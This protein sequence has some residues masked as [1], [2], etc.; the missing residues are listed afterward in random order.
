MLKPFEFA[1]EW[2]MKHQM[3]ITGESFERIL[4]DPDLRRAFDE[5]VESLSIPQPIITPF[6]EFDYRW[7]AITIR[8]RFR[9]KSPA[10]PSLFDEPISL[11]QA[12]ARLPNESG[13]YLICAADGTRLYTGWADNLHD[14]FGLLRDTSAG[15]TIPRRF[16]ASPAATIAFHAHQGDLIDAWRANVACQPPLLNLFEEIGA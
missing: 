7:L 1:V 11:T 3:N 14:Q 15:E 5:S 4:C 10:Q 13:V 8:K 16:T 2:A 9:K 12:E 6:S